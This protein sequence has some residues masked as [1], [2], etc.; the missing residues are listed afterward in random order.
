MS[1]PKPKADRLGRRQRRRVGTAVAYV[2]TVGAIILTLFPLYWLFVISTKTPREAFQTP[3]LP[4]D[5]M[6]KPTS[7][8]TGV[9][10]RVM[11]V[12]PCETNYAF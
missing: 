9:T 5:P 2:I 1:A 6:R 8:R 11:G 3:L 12:P 7:T 4:H 10:K